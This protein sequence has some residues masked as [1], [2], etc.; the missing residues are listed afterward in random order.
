MVALAVAIWW[1]NRDLDLMRRLCAGFARPRSSLRP[2]GFGVAAGAAAIAI[3]WGLA[4]L[5]APAGAQEHQA[6]LIITLAANLVPALAIAI[7]EE[8]FFRAFLLSGMAEDFGARTGLIASSAVYAVA[9]LVRSPRRF[10]V[11][12]YHPTVGLHNLASSLSQLG[13]PREAAPGLIGLF[14]LGLLLGLAFLRTGQVYFSIGL[15]ASLVIGAKTFRK[16]APGAQSAPGW[17]T[18]YGNPPLVSGLA[19]WMITVAMLI[20]V[21]F[22]R[23]GNRAGQDNR[24]AA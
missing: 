7:I 17:L 13:H 6:P 2:I 19:A 15:H 24:S 3:L 4:W 8:A 16:L 18:G 1:E 9:H 12:A 20:V 23:R 21:R 10:E 14:L 22:M 5:V 11:T